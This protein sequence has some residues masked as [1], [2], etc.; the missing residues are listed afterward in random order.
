[1][2]WGKK[3]IESFGGMFGGSGSTPLKSGLPQAISIKGISPSYAG[4]SKPSP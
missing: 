2:S 3:K 1:M 4:A